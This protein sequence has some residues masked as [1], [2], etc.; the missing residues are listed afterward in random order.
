MRTRSN[1]KTLFRKGLVLAVMLMCL[2][3]MLDAVQA[4][5]E[6]RLSTDLSATRFS[7]DQTAVLSITI[8]GTRS[9]KVA[10]PE[11]DNL[12]FHRRGQS[13]KMQVINGS[14]SSSV[15]ITYVIGIKLYTLKAISNLTK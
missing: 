8:D 13:S 7:V 15:T 14:F 6:S 4:G 1:Q 11:Q 2:Q 12:I 10:L 3:G 9:A 5:N